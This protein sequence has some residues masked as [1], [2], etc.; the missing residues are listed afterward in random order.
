MCCLIGTSPAS[1]CTTE[2]R[3]GR[4]ENDDAFCLGFDSHKDNLDG[5]YAKAGWTGAPT[6]PF[7]YIVIGLL[8]G[9]V[10]DEGWTGKGKE[11]EDVCETTICFNSYTKSSMI[12]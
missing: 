9:R 8:E 2:M 5:C 4:D 11:R 3:K 7:G 10:C 1:I 12:F 6:G